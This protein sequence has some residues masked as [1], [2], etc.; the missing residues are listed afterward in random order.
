MA[1]AKTFETRTTAGDVMTP[2]VLTVPYDMDLRNVAK[3]FVER[4]ISGA[5]VVDVMG[6]LVGVISIRDLVRYSLSRD[7]ELVMDSTFYEQARIEAHRIPAGFQVEDVNTG[8]VKDIM[9]P[10]VHS[11]TENA[12][13]KSAVK[14]MTKHHIHR[15]IVRRRKKPVGILSALAVL[16]H[17]A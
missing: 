7:D 13:L 11:V 16:E 12:S 3:L 8:E 5:P 15:V 2:G 4:D 1:K 10:V 6:E 9:T 17:L 14:I